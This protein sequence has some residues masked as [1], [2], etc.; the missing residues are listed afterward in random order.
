MNIKENIKK[1]PFIYQANSFLRAK[2]QE[3]KAESELAYYKRKFLKTRNKLLENDK[4][5]QSLRQRLA[6]RGIYPTR[7]SKGDLHIFLAYQRSNWEYILPISLKPFGQVTEFEWRS[8]GFDSNS[9]D[10]LKLRGSMNKVMV[11]EFFKA[12]SEKP[13]D[14]LVSYFTGYTVD[15]KILQKMGKAGTVIINFSWDDKLHFRGRIC[16][17]RWTGPA[18]L[19]SVVDLNLTNSTDSLFKYIVEGGLAIF[20]P[21]AAHPNI[22][23]PYN[24]PFKHDVSFVGKRYGWRPKFITKLRNGGI[25][26]TCFGDG[27]ENGRLSNEEMIKMYS[28]SRI[29]LGF[30]GVGYSKNLMCL[31]GRDFEIPMSGGLYL[32]QDNPELSLVYKIGREILTYKNE[33]DCLYKI[34]WVLEHSKK[35]E[36]IRKAGMARALRE[37]TWEKRF[38]EIFIIAGLLT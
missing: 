26:V 27:W 19:A 11:E 38:E 2:I 33:K 4:L 37:H 31:K 18:A 23:K 30:A 32:T 15:P 14:V 21:E 16:G 28:R 7:K 13:I 20:W 24:L 10:W 34:Q 36:R 3:K 8:K 35:A 9:N 17:G 12:N 29:N 6:Q 22:H 5:V 25:K 1:I